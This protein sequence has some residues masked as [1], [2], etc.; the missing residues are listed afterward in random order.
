MPWWYLLLVSLYMA[1][2]IAFAIF[3]ARQEQT[4]KALVL[5]FAG[6]AVALLLTVFFG[7][8]VGGAIT[9]AATF[10]VADR[11]NRSRGWAL[12]SFLLGPIAL[13]IVVILPKQVDTSTL[14]LTT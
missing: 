13:L 10:Y 12:L 3:Y 7:V 8:F 11:K 9:V 2:W 6:V 1:G 5:G 4:T 14:S